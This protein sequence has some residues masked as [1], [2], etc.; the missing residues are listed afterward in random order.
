M[1]AFGD[2]QARRSSAAL[3]GREIGAVD[4]DLDGGLEIGVVEHD[5]RVL[6]AHLELELL[7][8]V[9]EHA[10]LRDLAPR[11]HRAGEGDRRD[12]R[13]LKQGLP[14][15][16][17][18]AD[19]E[20]EHAG[21][22]AGTGDDLGQRMRRARHQLG[23][24]EHDGVAVAERRRDLPGGDRD[25]EIPGRDHADD[26]DRLTGELDVDAG[27]HRG[28]LLADQAQRFAGEERKNLAG[29]RDLADA[30]GQGLAF[31]AG[32]Q[33][34][35][36]FLAGDDLER[37][38]VQRVIAHLRRRLRPGGE[39][40]LGGGDGLLGLRLVGL[41]VFADDV[42]GVGGVDVPGDGGAIDP[43]AADEVLQDRSHVVLL[44]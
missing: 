17:A 11:L 36:L 16:R 22:N 7:H 15:H 26:S 34:A 5:Q 6:A 21:R 33:A 41:G 27:T 25:R 1:D 3:A 4:G 23:R 14:D 18:G 42:V 37:D 12:I 8:R 35:E 9:R 39:G 19:H 43:F 40:G 20:V 10:G 24:L 32:E 30:L 31:L 29:A 13:V 28:A 38:L 2:D 44:I